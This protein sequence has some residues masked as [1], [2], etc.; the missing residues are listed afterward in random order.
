MNYS[1][2]DESALEDGRT[3]ILRFKTPGDLMAW[4]R[5]VA[6][7]PDGAGHRPNTELDGAD[8][9]TDYHMYDDPYLI[10]EVEGEIVGAVFVVP[11]DPTMGYHRE[12]A[13]EFH[14]DVLPGWRRQGVGSALITSLV[15]WAK[16]RGDVRKIEVPALGWNEAVLGL[17][18]KHGFQEEGR[19]TKAWKVRTQEGHDE[20]D[21]I[22][23]MG[24][25]VGP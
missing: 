14:I 1:L 19:S 12:H 24:L 4:R 25:W 13:L 3:V 6:L 9:S 23:T 2:R 21:D 20:F 22:V 11:P 15:D 5:F 8:L 7:V 10:A 18:R 17:L 16:A